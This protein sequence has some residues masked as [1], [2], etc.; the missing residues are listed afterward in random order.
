MVQLNDETD[1]SVQTQYLY[2]YDE[3]EYYLL[4]YD[5]VDRWVTRYL[6]IK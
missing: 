6:V 2:E 3:F 5:E 1:D 4:Y